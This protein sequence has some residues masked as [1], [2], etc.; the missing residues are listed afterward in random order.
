MEETYQSKPK[1]NNKRVL[2]SVS[3]ITT[4]YNEE[5]NI[6]SFLKSLMEQE[7]L[8]GE[9]VVVDGGSNDDTLKIAV[10][11]FKNGLK[12]LENIYK[13]WEDVQVLIEVDS[14]GKDAVLDNGSVDE[15]VNKSSKESSIR[16]KNDNSE[17]LVFSSTI[18][19]LDNKNF[20]DNNKNKDNKI[21]IKIIE[22]KG[23]NI[24]QGRNIA[25]KST[26]NEIICVSDA[27]CILDKNWAREITRFV[28]RGSQSVVGGF[29]RPLCKSFLEKTL[30][31]CIMPRKEEVSKS[32]FMPSSRNICF[33][34]DIWESI[35]GYPEDMDYGEDMKFN[36]NLK[37]K[38]FKIS[39]NPDA[40]VYWKMR[41]SMV[42][43]FKQFFR[44][45]KGDAIGKMYLYRHIV[46]FGSFAFLLFIVFMSISLNLWFLTVIV[47]LFVGYVFKPYSR[48]NYVWGNCGNNSSKKFRKILSL[49]LI[50]F[51]LF[52]IDIAKISGY[53]YGLIFLYLKLFKVTYKD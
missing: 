37:A 26:K 31:V 14:L 51:L 20:K 11:F 44:Y 17:S 8:P 19:F 46:R 41:E 30:A 2:G 1:R 15:K 25:I 38:G 5:D 50:P 22:R 35:G 7:F 24:S 16:L 3:F 40:V 9:I 53:V 10:D 21:D 49:F 23:A 43:I 47:A 36:F 29:N 33:K 32:N 28:S 34:K 52:Y 12:S 42:D 13:D 4:V 6:F 18:S 48:L 27:G 39:Y 45:A